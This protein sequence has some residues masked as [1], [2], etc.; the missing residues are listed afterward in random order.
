MSTR[1]VL[2]GAFLGVV[3][4]LLRR[5]MVSFEDLPP[6]IRIKISE[7]MHWMSDDNTTN[8]NESNTLSTG[9]HPITTITT[10]PPLPEVVESVVKELHPNFY[11]MNYVCQEQGTGSLF[12]L[13]P[14]KTK[15]KP[16]DMQVVHR[17]EKIIPR[18]IPWKAV[19][20]LPSN[21][22]W[23]NSALWAG[24]D[25]G[26]LHHFGHWVYYCGGPMMIVINKFIGDRHI[27]YSAPVTEEE[28]KKYVYQLTSM[29]DDGRFLKTVNT[30]KPNV[31]T[32][33]KDAW[34]GMPHPTDKSATD[35]FDRDGH[36]YY[37]AMRQRLHG[38]MRVRG[39]ILPPPDVRLEL[40]RK[41]PVLTLTVRT[42]KGGFGRNITN[43][44]ELTEHLHKAFPN[45]L[46]IA[47]HSW[48]EYPVLEQMR[49]AAATDILFGIHGNA[50]TWMVVM[51]PQSVVLEVYP[52]GSEGT[53]K[54]VNIADGRHHFVFF[55]YIGRRSNL[56]YA[57]WP[58]SNVSNSPLESKSV[59]Y[60]KPFSHRC[61]SKSKR[62][63]MCRNLV[64]PPRV[65]ENLVKLGLSHLGSFENKTYH[66]EFDF[67]IE[68][69][70]LHGRILE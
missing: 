47:T 45:K 34:Y 1:W 4:V 51:P 48:S 5:S 56:T 20:D 36:K 31:T 24:E 66:G 62:R 3:V 6:R 33:Y 14:G 67:E 32:C 39:V 55:S 11:K 70:K 69:R 16:R 2:I 38:W 13:Y 54:G 46:D 41:R 22:I 64:M 37:H 60:G 57:T 52:F 9:I 43:T 27:V 49:I 12:L 25:F 58:S 61:K 53:T 10:I 17:V 18:S 26:T 19:E 8:L 63:W 7:G 40:Q 59:Y 68:D 30:N 28:Q 50:L 42:D 35:Y 23:S 44:A 65:M 15:S 29:F 21:T